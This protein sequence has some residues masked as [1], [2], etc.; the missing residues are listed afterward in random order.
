MVRAA[1]KMEFMVVNRVQRHWRLCMHTPCTATKNHNV[2][3]ALDT[4]INCQRHT[5]DVPTH[6]FSRVQVKSELL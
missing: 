5:A 2:N 4:A 6:L 3:I 1:A